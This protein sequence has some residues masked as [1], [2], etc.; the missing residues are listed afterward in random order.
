MILKLTDNP[1]ELLDVKCSDCRDRAIAH[2][3]EL[4]LRGWVVKEIYQHEFHVCG[5]C[6]PKEHEWEDLY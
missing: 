4:H 6:A 2:R 5:K 1:F 3:I